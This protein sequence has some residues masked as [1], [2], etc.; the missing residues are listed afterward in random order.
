MFFEKLRS[1]YKTSK[2]DDSNVYLGIRC[3]RLAPHTMFLDQEPYVKDFLHMYGFTTLRPASTPT[4]GL[5]LSKNQQPVEQ[6]EKDA[7]SKHPYR[8]VIGSL[9]YLEQCTRPDISFALN[10]LSRYQ[11]NPGL[12]H[13]QELKHLCRYIAGTQS[14]GVIYGKGVYPMHKKLQHD[15]SGP[16][17]CFV[18]SDHASDKDTRRSC[19]GY[20]F[21]SRGVQSAGALASK[22]QL[23]YLRLKPN[24]WPRLTQ[25]AKISG[26]VDF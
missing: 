11:S 10:R 17:T 18:D 2:A 4:S 23:L 1:T 6:S 26:S 7:M 5:P 24:L 3:R 16:L 19:T 9:R 20:I 21:F 14:Y 25:A 8:H 22:I 15:L 13:W 12:P